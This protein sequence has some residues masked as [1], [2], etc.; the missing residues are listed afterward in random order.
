MRASPERPEDR[1]TQSANSTYKE[2]RPPIHALEN[3]AEGVRLST[4]QRVARAL[5]KNLRIDLVE[6]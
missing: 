6:A 4:L 3:H 2:C 5:G 1:Q